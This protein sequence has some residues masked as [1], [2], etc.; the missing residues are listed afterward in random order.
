[1]TGIL[2]RYVSGLF[3]SRLALLLTGLLALTVLMDLIANSD[4][5][6]GKED[7]VSLALLRYAGLRLPGVASQ[8]IPI[9]VL[10]A[11]LVTLANLVRHSELV[12]ALSSGLSTFRLIAA[13][14][15]A[16]LLVAVLQFVV[17]DRLMPEAN[18]A[19][20]A[21]GVGDFSD[22]AK[23]DDKGRIWVRHG[24]DYVSFRRAE[25]DE[26]GRLSDITIFVRGE[27]GKLVERIEA[28][29]AD[30]RDG[31]WQLAEV[32][33][34]P[35]DS[36]PL[37]TQ[38]SMTWAATLDGATLRAL[39]LHP[40]ELGWGALRRMAE[41]AGF[42]NQ[43]SY[44]YQVWLHKKIARPL[45]TVVLILLAVATIQR[46]QSRH[47]AIM[48]FVVGI[49]AGFVYRIFDELVLTLGE[50]GLLPVVV[51]AWAPPLILG[52]TAAWVIVFRES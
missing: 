33:R 41:N 43:P 34:L 15:P 1:M 20:R 3:L 39:T 23:K 38:E 17:E 48:M 51:S 31:A 14:L 10:L 42:G 25:D 49:A 27:E 22:F 35:A 47:P 40:K 19:L 7:N 29:R 44:L 24:D 21:W 11:A 30:Y 36:G 50:A 2:D 37:A 13:F 45:A 32:R 46:V 8:V 12:A 4:D 5:I 6:V 9:A 26:T 18:A 52:A 16:A 28:E